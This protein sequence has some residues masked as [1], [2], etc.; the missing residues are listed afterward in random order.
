MNNTAKIIIVLTFITIIAGGVL[1]VLDS[2]T[3]PK[4]EAYQNNLKNEAVS[5]V[6]P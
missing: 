5:E 6:L 1:A 2:F 3:R 4:I